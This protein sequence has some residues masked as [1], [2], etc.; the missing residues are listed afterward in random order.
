M[1]SKFDDFLYK[2]EFV[3]NIWS[4]LNCSLLIFFNVINLLYRI[5]NTV[6]LTE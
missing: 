1:F 4:L 6:E 5:V 3:T 2:K